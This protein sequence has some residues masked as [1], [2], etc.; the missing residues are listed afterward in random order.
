MK[1]SAIPYSDDEM[2]WLGANRML[3]IGDYHRAF[4]QAFGRA[5]VMAVNLHSLRK[6]KGWLT[7]RSGCFERG[8]APHNKGRKCAPGE[9]GN[10]PNARRTQF[11][12]GVRQG[13]AVRL[14]KPIGTERVTEDGYVERKI[15]DGMPLQSRWRTVHLIRWEEINGPLPKGHCLKC[16][17]GDKANTAPANWAAIPRG[18]LPRLNGGRATKGLVFDG[19]P[20]ELKPTLLAVARLEHGARQA[21][22]RA[23]A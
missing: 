12:H 8:M 2:A 20:Q 6:R 1:G 10:H 4:V 17:D 5:D 9:G 18:V 3:V 15:H 13:V 21:R 7:G 22:K 23:L 19:A 16:L 11:K 14:Y